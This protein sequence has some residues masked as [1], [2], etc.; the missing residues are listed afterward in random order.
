[1]CARTSH[2]NAIFG[3][4]KRGDVHGFIFPFRLAEVCMLEWVNP[5]PAGSDAAAF[6]RCS[7]VLAAIVAASSSVFPSVSLRWFPAGEALG[8]R[9]RKAG[10]YSYLFLCCHIFLNKPFA[11]VK[12][13]SSGGQ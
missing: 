12:C 6:S 3:P 10:P 5:L 11:A 7:C 8:L 13:Q 4:E 2:I 1:M 9:L